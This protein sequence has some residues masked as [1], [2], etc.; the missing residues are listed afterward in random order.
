MR[1]A[2]YGAIAVAV[3]VAVVRVSPGGRILRLPAGVVELHSEMLVDSGTEVRGSASTVLRL[4]ADFK[5]RAAIVIRGDGVRL[6]GF[7]VDGNRDALEVRSGL[8]PWNTPFA[9]FTRANGVL[10]EGISGL[11]IENLQF[12]NI[13]GFALLASRARDVSIDRVSVSDSG[14]R[15]AA[16]RNNTSGGILLEEGTTDF[17]VTRCDLRRIR[18]NGVWTHS[19]YT[20]PRNARGV[21]AMNTFAEIGRDALQVGHATGVRVGWNAGMRIGYPAGDVDVEGRAVPVAIDT[22]GNVDNSSYAHNRFEEVEGKCIDLDGFHD[23]EVRENSCVHLAN[24]G[25]VF[26][27]TNPDMQS[28]NIRVTD[29]VIDG[30]R[31]GAIFVIGEK[32]LIARNRLLNVNTAHCDACYYLPDQPDMLRS[33]IYLGLGAERPDPARGNTIEDNEISGYKMK[34]RCIGIAPGIEAGWNTVRNNTC[35]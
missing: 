27:N 15:N 16:G 11:A 1:R 32:H 30:P 26:N 3:A 28:R 5:G 8:P 22:A 12:R 2:I 33:G 21:F 34:A 14:S 23:G 9:R 6:T 29:N 17:H 31:F 24:F 13:A 19:L 35:E 20:S 25:V 7:A 4:A 10:A 18:G